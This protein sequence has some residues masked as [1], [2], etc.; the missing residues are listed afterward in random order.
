M[1]RTVESQ[2][3]PLQAM[4]SPLLMWKKLGTYLYWNAVVILQEMVP[5]MITLNKLSFIQLA[6][7]MACM[8]G[9]QKISWELQAPAGWHAM[10]PPWSQPIFIL[11]F[12][13]PTCHEWHSAEREEKHT[14][15]CSLCETRVLSKHTERTSFSEPRGLCLLQHLEPQFVLSSEQ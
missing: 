4:E 8:A 6:V 7:P 12:P 2:L 9:S 13:P 3:L 11:S 10:S 1:L 14:F 15:S 5:E